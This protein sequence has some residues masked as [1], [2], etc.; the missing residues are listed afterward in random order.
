LLILVVLRLI[1]FLDRS[2]SLHKKL[3]DII[4]N[5][6]IFG[7]LIFIALPIGIKGAVCSPYL[8]LALSSINKA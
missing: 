4:D 1:D 7:K 2:L 6:N 3:L 8:F 5:N